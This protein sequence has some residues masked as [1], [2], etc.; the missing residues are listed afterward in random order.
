MSQQTDGSIRPLHSVDD[1]LDARIRGEPI[2]REGDK[3][4]V[5]NLSIPGQPNGKFVIALIKD[6]DLVLMG[7]PSGTKTS[8]QLIESQDDKKEQ[9]NGVSK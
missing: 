7:V 8:N 6:N 4:T 2:F 9:D 3:V 5:Q 1:V